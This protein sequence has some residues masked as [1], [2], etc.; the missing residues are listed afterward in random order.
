[1]RGQFASGL[2]STATSFI[3][4]ITVSLPLWSIAHHVH[5]QLVSV[6]NEK[7]RLPQNVVMKMR[8]RLIKYCLLCHFDGLVCGH[9]IGPFGSSLATLLP[10]V[11]HL[12]FLRA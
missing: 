3:L 5:F 9:H 2:T 11:H 8:I 4:I 12:L 6:A 7:D 10:P 1:M